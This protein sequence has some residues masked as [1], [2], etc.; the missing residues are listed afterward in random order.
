MLRNG[1]E[2]CR[3]KVETGKKKGGIAEK[4][5]GIVK[6]SMVTIFGNEQYN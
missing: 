6:G 4:I 3:T 2:D 1:V 5:K